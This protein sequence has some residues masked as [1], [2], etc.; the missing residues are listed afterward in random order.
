MQGFG[1]AL[2]AV[3]KSAGQEWFGVA[4]IFIKKTALRTHWELEAGVV[5]AVDQPS[6]LRRT[7][8]AIRANAF[9]HI[10]GRMEVEALRQVGRGNGQ[11]PQTIGVAAVFAIEMGV[12]IRQPGM[13]IFAAMA[14]VGTKGVFELTAAVLDGMNEMMFQKTSQCAKYGAFVHGRKFRF[15]I[16]ERKGAIDPGECTEYQDASGGGAD[17]ACLQT[18]F[19]RRGHGCRGG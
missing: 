18:C 7:R 6:T 9:E 2:C 5:F 8:L 15:Q 1:Q 3:L 17:A 4:L 13:E 12:K 16:G 10:V 11:A 19:E 14:I